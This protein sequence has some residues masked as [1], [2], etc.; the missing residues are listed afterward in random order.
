MNTHVLKNVIKNSPKFLWVI[1]LSETTF[2]TSV[3]KPGLTVTIDIV[4]AVLIAFM[5]G[6]VLLLAINIVFCVVLFNRYTSQQ[7]VMICN[8]LA[9]APGD[10]SVLLLM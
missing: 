9:I 1:F 3:K 7:N 4:H 10:P 2:V 8:R 5:C 6:F